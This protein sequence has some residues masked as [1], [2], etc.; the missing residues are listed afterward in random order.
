MKIINLTYTTGIRQL[1]P[2]QI[3]TVFSVVFLLLF[4]QSIFSQTNNGIIQGIVQDGFDHSPLEYVTVAVQHARF[5]KVLNGTIT[6]QKGRFKIT[7][8]APGQYRLK[9]SF[10][11]YEDVL[12]ADVMIKEDDILTD[13][14]ILELS[15]GIGLAEVEVVGERSLIEQHFDKIVYN[16]ENDISTGQTLNDMLRKVP[17]VSVDAQGNVSLRGNANIQVLIDGKPAT[18]FAGNVADALRAIPPDQVKKIEVI[19]MPSARYDAE[20]TAGVINIITKQAES[21][22]YNYSI[23]LGGGNQSASGNTNIRIK[24]RKLGFNLSA[25][26]NKMF[27]PT[28]NT[29]VTRIIETEE[30]STLLYQSGINDYRYTTGNIQTGLTYQLNSFHELTTSFRYSPRRRYSQQITDIDLFTNTL[31]APTSIRQNDN[32]GISGTANWSLDYNRK[33]RN[34]NLEWNNSIQL[35]QEENSSDYHI[36]ETSDKTVQL[37]ERGDNTGSNVEFTAQTDYLQKVN[38]KFKFELG[39]KFIS[40]DI[41]TISLQQVYNNTL[42]L[43]QP[44]EERS[45]NFPYRQQVAAA[46]AEGNYQL[47]TNWTLRTGLRLEHTNNLIDGQI[48]NRYTNLAPSLALNFLSGKSTL[49]LSYA[50]RLSRPGLSYLNPFENRSDPLN[51]RI[52]NPLLRPEL[53]DAFDINFSQPIKQ[54]FLNGSLY[55]HRTRDVIENQTSLLAADRTI[56][57]YNNIG[58]SYRVG[59]NAFFSSTLNDKF[60][61][62]GGSN[63]IYYNLSSTY[64][65]PGSY[66]QGIQVSVFGM[67]SC[68]FSKGWTTELIGAYLTPEWTAQQRNSSFY[69]Y[70]LSI[71]KDILAT[72]SLNLTLVNPLNKTI[73]ISKETTASGVYSLNQIQVPLRMISISFRYNLSKNLAVQAEGE[74]D[75]DGN[76]DL[77]RAESTKPF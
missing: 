30:V 63:L 75:R 3:I 7:G 40:R 46:Y 12:I 60:N 45:F 21:K 15:Q 69:T 19:T 41:Q 50:R 20:G 24:G 2:A 55:Y 34:P 73:N 57:T 52:G 22:G 6:D 1:F 66:N 32:T 48:Q 49:T 56:T 10:V 27:M 59:L 71:K 5:P 67:L 76:T 18:M 74:T 51:W 23:N 58:N 13:V 53:A 26:F 44:D 70:Q 61:L 77:K 38:D 54:T 64:L 68:Q 36:M 37:D 16:T 42:Q 11:G 72:G 9:F 65:S 35:A 4:S 29:Q 17:M 14:G 43:Y 31:A 8:M 62:K 47:I 39:G 33:F 28:I 25:G